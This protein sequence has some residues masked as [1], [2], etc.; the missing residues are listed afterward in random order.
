TN[1]NENL[2]KI[3]LFT[4]PIIWLG[5]I[6]DM[7]T[8]LGRGHTITYIF[9]GPKALLM[10]FLTFFGPQVTLG[11]RIELF[12]ILFA[13]G[14][15]VWSIRKN[16]KATFFAVLLSYAFLFFIFALPSIIYGFGHIDTLT[17]PAS[18]GN[19]ARFLETSISKSNIAYNTIDSTL[20]YGSSNRA[21]EL[22]FDKLLSQISFILAFIFIS[23]W[24]WQTKK[25]K[26]VA[27]I[28]NSRPER[29][30]FYLALLVLGIGYAG[31]IGYGKIN[32]W[33]D[34]LGIA[35]LIISWYGAWMFAV[36]T[37]DVA[38]VS[39]DKISNPNRPIT[40]NA[41][42][43]AEM[44]GSGHIWLMV[45]LLGSWS[46]GYYPFFMNLV[47]T[48]A[49]Y[50][51]SVPPLRLKRVP[52]LSSFLISV[53]CLSTVLAGFFFLS[54]DKTFYAFSSF[55]AIGILII[56]TLGTN[57]RDLKD[58]DGD[59]KEGIQTL[60]VIFAKNG[61]RMVA[62]FFALSFLLVPI[63]ISFYTSYIVAIPIAILGYR[64]VMRK[65]YDEK[66]IFY[67]YFA[68]IIS[69]VALVAIIY[70]LVNILQIK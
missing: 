53:A 56:F 43:E 14:W 2:A 59:R 32:S 48:A 51:Y 37:N 67:L 52:M 44:S 30:A 38:D 54:A 20:L 23:V 58:V 12:V 1:G 65:S 6:A 50:I 9:D 5:P 8:S 19:V 35:T 61:K 24:F 29:V 69:C 17:N 11:L 3:A 18:A 13:I 57:V 26:L 7:I 41:V 4:L 10:D 64:A 28:K 49:Y 55:L 22:G 47:F 31:V 16:I 70:W 15:Y 36:H 62:V 46:V 40:K 60:P 34:W 27:V 63:F 42:E 66:R 25:E 45:A 33:M 21:F 39:I 68:F